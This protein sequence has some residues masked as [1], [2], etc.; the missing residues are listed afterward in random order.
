[1]RLTV[2]GTPRHCSLNREDTLLQQGLAAGWP[3]ARSCRNGNCERCFCQLLSGEVIYPDHRRYRA[4]SIIAL[5]LA[6]PTANIVLGS[7]PLQPHQ[8]AWRCEIINDT[9]L[10]L[11]AGRSTGLEPACH[12][13]LI[14]DNSI[15]NTTLRRREGR[16]LTLDAPLASTA[17]SLGLVLIDAHRCGDWQLH[18]RACSPSLQWQGLDEDTARQALAVA[19]KGRGQWFVTTG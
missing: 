13:L 10:L 5:C 8:R 6:R 7:L 1:M 16:R 18:N 12:V 11:P 14:H 15:T 3:L 19:R 9:S 2:D 17:P 4:G